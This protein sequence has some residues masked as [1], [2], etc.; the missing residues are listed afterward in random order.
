MIR[1][2]EVNKNFWILGAIKLLSCLYSLFNK[3][4]ISGR[5]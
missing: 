5:G 2:I 4:L 3:K 1:F